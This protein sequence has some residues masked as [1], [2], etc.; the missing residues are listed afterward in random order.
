MSKTCFTINPSELQAIVISPFLSQVVFPTNINIKLNYSTIAISN[1]TN[2]LGI[3][4]DSKLLFRDHIHK[5]QNKLSCAVGIL[6]K[7]KNLFFSCILK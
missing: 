7:P 4:I 1:S 3:L 6:G 2:Y 5:V